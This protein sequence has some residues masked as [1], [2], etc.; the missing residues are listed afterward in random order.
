MDEV[1]GQ[2]FSNEMKGSSSPPSLLSP[3]RFWSHNIQYT[4]RCM[5]VCV[6]VCVCTACVCVDVFCYFVLCVGF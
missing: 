6:C 5:C 2:F 4:H 3:P 1:L